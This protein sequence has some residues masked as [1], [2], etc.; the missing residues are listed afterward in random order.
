MV[1]LVL[2]G[3]QVLAQAKYRPQR[4]TTSPGG[5]VKLSSLPQAPENPR[6]R[7]TTAI[8]F[9]PGPPYS[10]AVVKYKEEQAASDT[11]KVTKE[12]DGSV[13]NPGNSQTGYR[14]IKGMA[15]SFSS[16]SY[17]TQEAL[18]QNF[19]GITQTLYTPPDPVVAVG[20]NYV[21][22]AV[23]HSFAIYTKSG[24]KISQINFQDF[25]SSFVT[26]NDIITDPKVIYD[27]Y[28]QR[29][30][31][32]IL[33]I[34]SANHKG[35]YLIAAS[36]S[37][38]PTGSWYKYSSDATRDGST[39][40]SNGP[41]YPGLGYDNNA[42]YVT[43]NQYASY[44]TGS[45]QYA[46]IRIFDKSQLYNYQTL[47]YIDFDKMSDNY[48]HAFTIKPAQHFGTTSTA[49]F[50]NTER[51][52]ASSLTLW[53]ITNPLSSPTISHTTVNV[54]SYSSN[55]PY[56]TVP[57]KGSTVPI[58]GNNS[59]T[60]D[61]IYRSGY[62]YTAFADLHDWG[63]G[64]V[65]AIRY[66]KINV[67]SN[68]AV[69]DAEYGANGNN[70]IYPAIFVDEY[71]NI[72]MVFSRSS[73]N[74][75]PNV[76]WTIRRTSD[77]AVQ[78]SQLLH[79]G[80]GPYT[81]TT[82]NND[83]RWG[84]YSGIGLDGNK[85]TRIWF[86]GEW[87][88]NNTN[89]W[90]TQIGSFDFYPNTLTNNITGNLTL[91]GAYRIPNS[92]SVDSGVTLTI[93]SGSILGFSNGASL[94]IKPGS[95]INANGSSGSPIRFQRLDPTNEWGQLYLKGNSNQFTWCLFDGGYK[96]VEI[97]SRNNSFSNCTFRNG[98]RGISSG[99]NKSGSGGHSS[100][101]LSNCMVEDNSTVGVVAYPGLFTKKFVG[102]QGKVGIVNETYLDTLNALFQ[103]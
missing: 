15:N 95:K 90:S 79:S 48:G 80:N 59:E 31:M 18:S 33:D 2:S 30:V 52:G 78:A 56:N 71:G 103:L 19:Q 91:T 37:S 58:E 9:H 47:T 10:P 94:T 16:P 42:V 5:I 54:A 57:Q 1:I 70:Y 36:Q 4:G 61:V 53:R 40:T 34:N 21:L 8:P 84:D 69:I 102:G 17:N 66:L 67:S 89:D 44:D 82:R 100:F 65:V 60:Q 55:S 49:Y 22:E 64:T 23:N 46:K 29:F 88:T 20:P 26:N 43:S 45:F 83:A 86:C 96:T 75:Y 50:L 63:S 51:Y 32:L 98:W 87:A 74:E 62:V 73:S 3:N 68:T 92:V 72:A 35:D 81:Y 41:D 38:D 27:Q 7:T 97:Q 6:H 14:T 101:T 28:A 39:A 12:W 77:N 11:L 24:T 76:R 13:P 25:F 93:N 99:S 85:N